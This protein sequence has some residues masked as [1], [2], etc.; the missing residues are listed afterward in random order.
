MDAKQILIF[1]SQFLD[2]MRNIFLTT[3]LI[4]LSAFCF[5]QKQNDNSP[6]LVVSINIEH[7]RADYITRYW[8][9]FQ[10]GGFRRLVDKGSVFKNTRADIHNI[11]PTTLLST[12]YTGTYPSVHG[13]VGDKWLNQLTG[14]EV[15]A[16]I[17][18]NVLTMGSDSEMGNASAKQLKVFTLGDVLKQQSNFKSKVYSVALNANAAVLTAGHAADAAFWFDHSNGNFVTSSYYAKQFPEWAIEFNHKKLASLYFEREWD[19]LLPKSSYKAS[20]ADDYILES[21][22]WKKWNTF[23]YKLPKIAKDQEHPLEIIKTTPFG[24]MMLRDFSAQLIMN[25]ELGMDDYT[26]LLSITFSTLDYANKW[27]TPNSIETQDIILR[28]DIEIASLLSLLDKTMGK[29]NYLVLLTS[30]ST[31]GYPVSVLK[32]DFG[33]NAGEFSPQS[34][35]ALLRSYLNAIYGVGDWIKMYNEEQIFLNHILIERN[36]LTLNDMREKIALFM[37]QFT[38]VKAALP[39]H[40]I[41]QGNLNNPRFNVIENSYCVQRSGD[42]LILLDEGWYPTFRYNQ[43]DYS[44]EN[45]VPLIFYGMYSKPGTYY[46]TSSVVDIV[47]TICRFLNIIQPNNC[48][49]KVLEQVF[50]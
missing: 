14:N 31:A 22:Y 6:K 18:N 11:K 28:M 48:N 25:E 38:G 34:A 2:L 37:N 21:G 13:V 9:S 33:F 50:W 46:E 43:V 7:F 45:R 42:V 47:P 40:L 19:L 17:D 44:S 15:F 4:L 30:A 49:G 27:F 1:G 39:S 26:D 16:T 23:P 29:D 12:I 35:L 24:N 20:F 32:N 3:I 10:L 41:E 8:D 5:A 36:N